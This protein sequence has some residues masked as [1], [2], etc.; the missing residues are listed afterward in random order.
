[1]FI[2]LTTGNLFGSASLRAYRLATQGKKIAG[3]V[4]A[5][6]LSNHGG[7]HYA[8]MVDGVQYARSESLC[9][10]G[11]RVGTGL[12]VTYL[13]SNP[14]IATSGDPRTEWRHE[15]LFTLIAPSVLAGFFYVTRR[16]RAIPHGV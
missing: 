7:C 16:G 4:T 2:A 14:K 10:S 6:N 3:T 8:Y 9:G 5:L 12:T 13:P 15:L 1:M 11:N